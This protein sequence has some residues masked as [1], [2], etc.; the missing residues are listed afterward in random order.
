MLYLLVNLIK[1]EREYLLSNKNYGFLRHLSASLIAGILFSLIMGLIVG[2]KM[3]GI[4]ES[5]HVYRFAYP[6]MINFIPMYLL[7]GLAFGA[8]FGIVGGL[9]M[10]TDE[11]DRKLGFFANIG[12]SYLAFIVIF[13]I[14]GE[15]LGVI[16]GMFLATLL[17]IAGH[18]IRPPL[19]RIYFAVFFISVFF[20]Y[21]WQWIRQHFI[22]SP[23]MPHPN[24]DMVDLT[25]TLIWALVFLL[26]L[27][28]FL[29]A[30]FKLH[31]K[32]FYA[33]GSGLFA[34]LFVV[35]TI[36]FYV[37]PSGAT[38]QVAT[39]LQ[40]EKN[41]TDVKVALIGIDGFWWRVIDPLIEQGKMPNLQ[42]LIDTGASGP[43]ETLLPTFSAMIWTSISTGKSPQKHGVTSFLVWKF[44]WTGYSLPCHI[45]P[46]STV[47]LGWMTQSLLTV[48]PI[49]NQFLDAVPNWL[50]LSDNGVTVGTVNW[51]VSWPADPVDG[52]IVTDHCLYNKEYITKNFK[53]KEGNTPYD[54]YPQELYADLIQF[55]RTPQS[56]TDEEITRFINIDTP[57]FL[58]EFKA[59]DTYDYIDIAYMASMFKYS[60]PEDLTFASTTKYLMETQQPDFTC[61]YLD[62]VD[63]MEHQYLRYYFADQHPDKLIPENLYRYRDLIENYYLYMDEVIGSYV[64]VADTN[65]IFIIISDHG[66]DEIMLPTG[67]YNHM[68]APPGV[69]VCSGPGIK[70]GYKINN[71]HVFDITPTILQA[72]GLPVAEDFDGK[73]LTDIFVDPQ[74]VRTIPTYETGR[75]A[76]RKV[77]ESNIDQAYKDRLKALGYT[78]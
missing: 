43:L 72:F 56:L 52:F 34:I 74:P 64:S 15:P 55:S 21:S 40:I 44:P 35:G 3:V 41:P 68:D 75:R 25:F 17:F 18:G 66:F 70:S 49:T 14:I 62:G 26:L 63:S 38:R 54:I 19:N 33:L 13:L 9:L 48:A 73:V 12:I 46:P 45:T 53:E 57:E 65:T 6:F 42:K 59:I 23:F 77:M 7:L 22:I 24:A 20:N 69:F 76:S 50:M 28:I 10:R 5:L 51:W 4:N 78:Q 60:Y 47:E 1:S 2:F 30:F 8:V 16:G 36:Y 31:I 71:A 39:D 32:T 67:H 29:K 58:E 27:R 37:Q 11:T 61:V